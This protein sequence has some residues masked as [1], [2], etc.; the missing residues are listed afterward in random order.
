M[1]ILTSSRVDQPTHVRRE[2]TQ[3]VRGNPGRRVAQVVPP[4]IG[5]YD[6]VARLGEG[7]NLVAPAVPEL[8][9]TVEEYHKR[10]VGRPRRPHMQVHAVPI[11]PMSVERH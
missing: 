11:D 2:Q 10:P 3:V 9:K 7:R 6:A 4:L 5:N 8:G 1:G